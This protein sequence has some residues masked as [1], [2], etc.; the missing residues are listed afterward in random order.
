MKYTCTFCRIGFN[1]EPY[2]KNAQGIFHQRNCWEGHLAANGYEGA[3]PRVRPNHVPDD[4]YPG[5]HIKRR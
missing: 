3:Q 2:V 1:T 4:N 5:N